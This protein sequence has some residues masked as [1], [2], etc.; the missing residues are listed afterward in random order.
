MRDLGFRLR[1]F[2]SRS[3][4]PYLSSLQLQHGSDSKCGSNEHFLR[5]SNAE[6][7][8]RGSHKLTAGLLHA[9]ATDT[10]AHNRRHASNTNS[11]LP[12]SHRHLALN[13]QALQSL[14]RWIVLTSCIGIRRLNL[15]SYRFRSNHSRLTTASECSTT[16]SRIKVFADFVGKERQECC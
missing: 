11:G 16:K 2:C 12:L 5:R 9:I 6:K 7:D 15:P 1:Q 14:D 4:E 13:N 8:Q 3:T 10:P